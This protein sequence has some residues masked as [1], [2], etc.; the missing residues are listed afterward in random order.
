METIENIV[1]TKHIDEVTSVQFNPSKTKIASAS[2]DGSFHICDITTGMVVLSQQHNSPI[3]CLDWKYSEEYLAMGDE[4]GHLI[5]WNMLT[6]LEYIK[7]KV[8][9]GLVSCLV[10]TNVEKKIIVAGIGGSDRHEY[11]IKVFNCL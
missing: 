1:M 10:T 3:I 2:L 11:S 9:T 5:L 4:N 6:G 8:F 7:S